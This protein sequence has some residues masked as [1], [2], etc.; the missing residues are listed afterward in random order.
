MKFSE[1]RALK[2]LLPVGFLFKETL[3]FYKNRKL[4]LINNFRKNNFH[5]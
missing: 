1:N 2:I 3:N 5:C 4:Y